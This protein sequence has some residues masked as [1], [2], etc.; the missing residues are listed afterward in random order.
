MS[1]TR[2]SI[3]MISFSKIKPI[4]V[5]I[6]PEIKDLSLLDKALPILRSLNRS[7]KQ[8]LKILLFLRMK[9]HL[10][11][12]PRLQ[13]FRLWILMKKKILLLKMVIIMMEMMMTSLIILM[14]I[15]RFCIILQMSQNMVEDILDTI[16]VMRNYHVKI[17]RET[18][19]ENI[20]LLIP[21]KSWIKK[22]LVSITKEEKV[23]IIQDNK[24]E[25]ML[26]NF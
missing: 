21:P 14:I 17:S 6:V 11:L 19:W 13:Q 2:C 24:L 18:S 25:I 16:I 22:L 23:W 10:D 5:V 15:S 8:W 9:T 20:S 3:H 26:R 1:Q 4:Q 7:L 12:P